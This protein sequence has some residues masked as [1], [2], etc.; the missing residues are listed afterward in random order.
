MTNA[1]LGPAPDERS[2]TPEALSETRYRFAK[3]RDADMADNLT[4]T[5]RQ[6][7]MKKI[8]SR[9]TK[10]E[11]QLRTALWALGHR[12]RIRST[13]EGKPD[14]IFPRYR[15]AIFVDGCFWHG[16]PIHATKPKSNAD[17]WL[18]KLERNRARDLGVTAK[19]ASEGWRVHRVW[20]HEIRQDLTAV[21]R[22]VLAIIDD[23]RHC[24]I[25]FKM[26]D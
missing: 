9:N 18:P 23:V 11:L 5:Q 2:T 19:L 16:C 20:E 22:T 13:L 1:S 24:G 15:L 26:A 21:V 10:P 8:R 7:C 25:I 14:I 17:Y 6:A 4:T 3:R 12:Y